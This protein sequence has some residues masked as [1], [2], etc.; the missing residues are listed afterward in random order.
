MEGEVPNLDIHYWS[1]VCTIFCGFRERNTVCI[2][3]F[4]LVSSAKKV[5]DLVFSMDFSVHYIVRT[6]IFISTKRILP[7]VCNVPLH[8]NYF[9][10]N[11]YLLFNSPV[12]GEN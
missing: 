12:R 1:K 8:E 11:T 2:F 5:D 4:V 3:V 7:G 10:F 6:F 9:L